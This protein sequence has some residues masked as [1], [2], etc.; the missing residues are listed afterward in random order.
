MT[1]EEYNKFVKKRMRKLLFKKI[2]LFI[3]CPLWVLPL[4]FY[5]SLQ[6]VWEDISKWVE[7]R[8]PGPRN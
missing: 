4:I 2:F 8:N 3:T 1:E 7:E 6:I 5:I